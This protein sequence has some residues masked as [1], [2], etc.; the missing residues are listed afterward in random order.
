MIKVKELLIRENC[1]GEFELNK[2]NSIKGKNY[3]NAIIIKEALKKGLNLKSEDISEIC[4]N[5]YPEDLFK[6]KK[7]EYTIKIYFF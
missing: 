1:E 5:T 3:Y 7:E 6:S 2:L 4:K